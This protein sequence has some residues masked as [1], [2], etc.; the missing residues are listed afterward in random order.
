MEITR[1]VYG[2]RIFTEL[3]NN[4]P[5]W[6]KRML[7]YVPYIITRSDKFKVFKK[8]EHII[9]KDDILRLAPVLEVYGTEPAWEIP[10]D[11]LGRDGGAP[12]LQLDPALVQ[13]C[14]KN[15]TEM[16]L[17]KNDFEELKEI[18]LDNT[19]VVELAAALLFRRAKEGAYK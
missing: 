19:G 8:G 3:G 7:P 11:S 9:R 13:I 16:I 6:V 4:V 10:G 2:R 17:S 1:D 5:L 15:G 18:V 14:R 12:R